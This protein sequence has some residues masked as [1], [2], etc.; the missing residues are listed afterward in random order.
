M[1]SLTL[2][3]NPEYV[4]TMNHC[5]STAELVSVLLGGVGFLA[6]VVLLPMGFYARWQEDRLGRLLRELALPGLLA[7][8]GGAATWLFLP[9]AGP[10]GIAG[11]AGNGQSELVKAL[12]GELL[13]WAEQRSGAANA[14]RQSLLRR[15]GLATWIAMVPSLALVDFM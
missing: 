2:A 8:L 14:T 3:S 13:A 7:V 9:A 15:L 4:W 10:W 6:L 1:L 5:F 12:A 11:V